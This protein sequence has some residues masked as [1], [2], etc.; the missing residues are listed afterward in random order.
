MR[1][2]LWTDNHCS[3]VKVVSHC[4]QPRIQLSRDSASHSATR[5]SSSSFSQLSEPP[6]SQTRHL[7]LIKKPLNTW[8][9]SRSSQKPT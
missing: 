9:L 5:I 4:L 8:K 3:Q 2:H 6:L 7:L 1:Q